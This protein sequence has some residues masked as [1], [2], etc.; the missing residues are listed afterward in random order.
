MVA[1]G[2]SESVAT[3]R[4]GVPMRPSS[5]LRNVLLAVLA[6]MLVVLASAAPS[7]A[8][9]TYQTG[10]Q[11]QVVA[12]GFTKPNGFAFAPDGRIFV[13]EDNGIVKVIKTDGS[14]Q[15]VLDLS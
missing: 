10:F 2:C 14:V 12:G 7:L 4:T 13:A 3:R 9:P 6:S 11:E 15:Q 5:S 1:A 8:A